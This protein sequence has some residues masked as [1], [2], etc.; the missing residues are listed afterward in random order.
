MIRETPDSLAVPLVVATRGNLVECLH[1]GVF[2]V[3]DATGRVLSSKG[4][5]DRPVFMRSCAKP[6]Q[7]LPMIEEGIHIRLGLSLAQLA[8]VAASHTG[9]AVHVETAAGILAK[10]GLAP[11]LLRCGSH[12]PFDLEAANAIIKRGDAPS[13]LHNNCSG[14]HIGMLLLAREHDWDLTTYTDPRHPV[15]L[16]IRTI[17]SN[18]ME[19][20]EDRLIPATDG[21]GVPTYA[22][23]PIKLA[24]AYAR[25]GLASRG[26]CYANSMSVIA[27]AMMKNPY[28]VAGRGM[29]ET[30]LM[31]R[32]PGLMILKRGAD[33][34]LCISLPDQALGIVVKIESGSRTA[35]NVVAMDILHQLGVIDDRTVK[36]LSFLAN[37]PIKTWMGEIV[38]IHQSVIGEL[39]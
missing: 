1:T 27:S 35:C 4:S 37:T 22:T 19:V 18:A 12:Y 15:Q 32:Y 25:L 39:I 29:I 7:A 3:V 10:C 33:G 36:E 30:A 16:R 31:E 8:L 5:L 11:D 38:G 17:L 34:L 21:C 26:S 24:T 28:I 9:E 23:E 14:K 2:C 20:S 6:F 13:A